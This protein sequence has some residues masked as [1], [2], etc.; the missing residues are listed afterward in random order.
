MPSKKAL[1]DLQFI[2]IRH[3]L[4]ELGAFLDRMERHPGESDHRLDALQKALPILQQSGARRGAALLTALS[5]LSE[6]IPTSAAFQG[7][8]GAP[9]ARKA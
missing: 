4:I 5:D 8:C 3:Q 9:P 6:E 7:A 1:L 2:E